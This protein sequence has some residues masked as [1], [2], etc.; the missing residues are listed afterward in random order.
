MQNVF[1]ALLFGSSALFLTGCGDS[2]PENIA[3]SA[4]QPPA[5]P[6]Q[7][8]ATVAETTTPAVPETLPCRVFDLH[9]GATLKALPAN[10]TVKIWLPLPQDNNHQIIETLTRE[11]PAKP[12]IATEPKYGN[13]I[14]YFE[15]RAVESEPL[16][17]NLSYRVTRQEVE[18]LEAGRATVLS[19]EERQR[20]LTAN[21]MVPLGGKPA[22][23]LTDIQLL[24]EDPLG[25]AKVLYN[26]V[27]EHMKYD[28]SRPGYGTG[29]AVWACDSRFGNCTDFHSLF[30]SMS[31]T[32]GVPAR[33]EIG[34]PIPPERGAGK[35][36]GYHCWAYF[37]TPNHG[38]VPV[39]ISEA[40]KH[41]EFKNYYFGNLTADRVTFTVGRDIDLVPKQAGKPLNF[42]VYPHV[43][44]NGRQ[45][46]KEQ[47]ELAFRY[48]D[49][50]PCDE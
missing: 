26:R 47:I 21:T 13:K 8:T 28:K 3:R 4:T 34:F 38:W 50:A 20:F 44:V 1:A 7:P 22:D 14:L 39:D 45:L 33:F 10:A 6:A 30:I 46:P 15:T 41:P 43:E 42:F 35:I 23:L 36:G 37:F 5:T 2:A 18:G 31:R 11:L 16:A 48:E 49:Q 19:D 17:F 40:D 32:K 12:Q 27:D 29:D 9:Y 24:N 25:L